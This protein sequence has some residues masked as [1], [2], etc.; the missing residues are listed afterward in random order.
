MKKGGNYLLDMQKL[1]HD[2]AHKAVAALSLVMA[3]KSFSGASMAAVAAFNVI[4]DKGFSF[5][6]SLSHD[7]LVA[8]LGGVVGIVVAAKA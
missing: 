5:S 4:A 6:P 3:I 8:V 2:H 7:T 1:T